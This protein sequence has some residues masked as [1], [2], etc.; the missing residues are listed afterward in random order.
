[1]FNNIDVK[2]FFRIFFALIFFSLIF[3]FDYWL[4][5]KYTSPLIVQLYHIVGLYSCE[6]S[7]I[8][9][10]NEEIEFTIFNNEFDDSD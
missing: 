9:I 5:W 7:F 3:I 4:I 2:K 6:D 10:L 8:D 1:M